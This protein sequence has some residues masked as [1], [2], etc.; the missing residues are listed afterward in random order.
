[1]DGGHRASEAAIAGLL[2]R[3]GVLD[4][5]HPA[6]IKRMSPITR[7]WRGIETGT[8]RLAPGFPG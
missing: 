7:N 3:L 6:T 8:W 4:A 2:V 1:L 5:N